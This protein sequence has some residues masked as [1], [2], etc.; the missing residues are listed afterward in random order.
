VRGIA[1]GLRF[2]PRTGPATLIGMSAAADGWRVA[3]LEGEAVGEA[4]RHL[5]GVAVRFRPGD[6]DPLAAASSWIAAGVTHHP[7][8]VPGRIGDTLALVARALGARA[9][10]A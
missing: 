8:L 10:A 4:S 7:V 9:I 5:R 3:W 6:R 2:A 1:S